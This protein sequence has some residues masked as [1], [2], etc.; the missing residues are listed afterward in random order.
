MREIK[1]LKIDSSLIGSSLDVE[2]WS[3]DVRII[4]DGS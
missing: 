4:V 1:K 2:P 3:L